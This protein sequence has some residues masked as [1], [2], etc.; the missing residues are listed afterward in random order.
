M[1]AKTIEIDEMFNSYDPDEQSYIDGHKLFNEDRYKDV[2]HYIYDGKLTTK[3]QRNRTREFIKQDHLGWIT[4]AENLKALSNPGI[5]VHQKARSYPSL[6]HK[7]IQDNYLYMR[8]NMSYTSAS[9]RKCDLRFVVTI[10]LDFD[11]DHLKD[12]NISSA[13]GL[14]EYISTF[15]FDVFLIIRT[16]SG[17]HVHLPISPYK[18]NESEILHYDTI[19]K[20][21]TELLKADPKCASAEHFFRVPN[22]DN[23]VYF[24]PILKPKLGFYENKLSKYSLPAIEERKKT[25]TIIFGKN[26]NQPAIKKLLAGDFNYS[27]KNEITTDKIG[28]NNACFT[29]ALAMYADNIAKCDAENKLLEWRGVINNKGFSEKEVKNT[30]NHAYSGRYLGPKKFY[31]EAL[32]GMSFIPYTRPKARGTRQNHFSEI[33]DDLIKY[34]NCFYQKNNDHLESS[35]TKLAE[36]LSEFS[37]FTISV[38]SLKKV[39]AKMKTDKELE[40]KTIRRGSSS[41]SIFVLGKSLIR[42]QSVEKEEVKKENNNQRDIQKSIKVKKDMPI[43]HSANAYTYLYIGPLYKKYSILRKL[44]LNIIYKS[45]ATDAVSGI[46][47]TTIKRWFEKIQ[48]V[49]VQS[50]GALFFRQDPLILNQFYKNYLFLFS[51]YSVKTGSGPPILSPTNLRPVGDCD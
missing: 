27:N 19:L 2:L 42:T 13:N 8:Y 16:T 48:L 14:R 34:L 10:P 32:T 37:G 18:V 47:Y 44:I 9:H 39:I 51:K 12:L 7:I 3:T 20:K 1:T 5:F 40:V 6:F 25:S 36:D 24:N 50:H 45:K 49:K 30:L 46:L 41:V 43:V 31:V 11:E 35:Q 22:P 28:R 29:L 26:M 23:I 33:R 15:G 17:Y 4:L 21:I 38:H